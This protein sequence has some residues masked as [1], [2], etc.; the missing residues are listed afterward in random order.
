MLFL[1]TSKMF[2]TVSVLKKPSLE[3]NFLYNSANSSWKRL[4]KCC[5]MLK[6]LFVVFQHSRNIPC[7]VSYNSFYCKSSFFNRYKLPPP[8]ENAIGMLPS[9][10]PNSYPRMANMPVEAFRET[11]EP[12]PDP[13]KIYPPGVV[14]ISY[15]FG[16]PMSLD[17]RYAEITAQKRKEQDTMPITYINEHGFEVPIPELSPEEFEVSN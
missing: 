7:R 1:A 17:P 6:R 15:F 10:H 8:E 2:C 11:D 12:L 4:E 9:F 13:A 16:P 14:A 5:Q 3:L